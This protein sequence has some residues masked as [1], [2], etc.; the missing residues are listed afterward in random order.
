MKS[1]YVKVWIILSLF[2]GSLS[3]GQQEII[4]S[5]QEAEALF[6]D[7]NLDLL[8]EKLEIPKAEAAVLQAK[9]WP[10]PTFSVDEVNFWAL[11][12][13]IEPLGEELPPLFGNFGKHFQFSFGLEQLIQTAGKRKKLMAVEQVTA[14][15]AYGYLEDL[16]RNL[17]I[18]FRN[19]L[20]E[21]Q[22]L[23][24]QDRIYQDQID[25]IQELTSAFQRQVDLGHIS[26]SELVRL[27]AL[28]LQFAK[29][30]QE[31]RKEINETQKELKILMRLSSDSHLVISDEDYLVDPSQIREL[32]LS[33]LLESARES[34]PDLKLA[35]LDEK[36]YERLFDYEK[37]QRTPDIN[38]KVGYDRG[39][40]ILYNFIGFGV[41]IEL[42]LFN[43]NQ[44]NIEAARIGV[45]QSQFKYD[46][47]MET[48]ENELVLA[49]RNLLEALDF[50]ESIDMEYETALEEVLSGYIRSFQDRNISLLEFIDFIEAY[51]ENK[52]I[53]LEA[54]KDLHFKAEEL[55]YSLGMD[56]IK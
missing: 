33:E 16:L 40:G 35:S 49:Y 13:Q 21:L 11:P 7:Q 4:L 44:G 54:G 2:W 5:R 28:E 6:L 51:I 41:D 46:H 10:N 24:F 12:G 42:P 8:A 29:Y 19:L 47:K 26:R 27:R 36:Y 50:Y 56:V 20:T 32:N 25:E 23:Q 55:N 37:A 43:K 9:L 45:V 18:E 14:D 17:K 53:I 52:E 1:S 39:G 34:R 22:F 30:G 31:I 15:K 38:L 48:I 3:Y